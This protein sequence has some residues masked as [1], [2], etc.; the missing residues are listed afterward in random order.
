VEVIEL[1]ALQKIIA[2]Q[3]EKCT[4]EIIENI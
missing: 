4:E 1:E 3:H 2:E